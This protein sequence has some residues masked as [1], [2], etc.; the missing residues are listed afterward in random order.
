M[1]LGRVLR[2]GTEVHVKATGTGEDVL[3]TAFPEGLADGDLVA[4]EELRSEPGTYAILAAFGRATADPAGTAATLVAFE[5]GMRVAADAAM[6]GRV[7]VLEAALPGLATDAELAAEALARTGA[8]TALDGRVD[9]LELSGPAEAITRAAADTA[10]GV[11]IDGVVADLTAEVTRAEAAESA[12]DVRVD[13]L[14]AGGG[15][16]G[17]GGGAPL[18]YATLVKLGV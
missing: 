10:L 11:R 14:E 8:D 5:A 4:V 15:G 18:R 9:V 3:V 12:L 6:D 1:M 16:G 13:A 7:D 17:G 2:L